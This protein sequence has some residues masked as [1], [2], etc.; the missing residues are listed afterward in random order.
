MG[1]NCNGCPEEDIAVGVMTIV[2]V[3]DGVTMVAGV[4]AAVLPPPHPPVLKAA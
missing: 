4:T 1:C 2:E 3:P